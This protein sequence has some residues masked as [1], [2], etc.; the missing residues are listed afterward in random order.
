MKITETFYYSFGI[1]GDGV[2]T[3]LQLAAG[4]STEVRR[5]YNRTRK[6]PVGYRYATNVSE[7]MPKSRQRCASSSSTRFIPYFIAFLEIT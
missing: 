1:F 3:N 4:L 5:T 7:A 2:M 6:S